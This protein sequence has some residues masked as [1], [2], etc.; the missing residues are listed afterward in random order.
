MKEEEKKAKLHL[1]QKLSV[2]FCVHFS[3]VQLLPEKLPCDYLDLQEQTT[4]TSNRYGRAAW[5]DCYCLVATRWRRFWGSGR[6]WENEAEPTPEDVCPNYRRNGNPKAFL[7]W[8]LSLKWKGWSYN[9]LGGRYVWTLLKRLRW[10]QSGIRTQLKTKGCGGCGG[11]RG[12]ELPS[13]FHGSAPVFLLH[14]NQTQERNSEVILWMPCRVSASLFSL[15]LSEVLYSG[16]F[17]RI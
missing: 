12:Y 14:R 10:T 6:N 16:N 13:L 15:C 11:G 2:S 4:L 7:Q 3:G 8:I 5:G 1:L 17:E 9:I